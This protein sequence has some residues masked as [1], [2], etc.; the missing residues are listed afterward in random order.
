MRLMTLIILFFIVTSCSTMSQEECQ[1]INWP[2]RGK[3]DGLIGRDANSF[4]IYHEAKA[5]IKYDAT[6]QG[7]Y[8]KSRVQGIKTFCNNINWFEMGKSDGLKNRN[9]SLFPAYRKTKT[10]IEYD[11]TIQNKYEKGHAEGVR[12]FCTTKNWFETG[13]SDG[14]E[15]RSEKAFSPYHKRCVS[16]NIKGYKNRYEKGRAQGIK[17]FYI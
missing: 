4:S 1:V 16:Y 10:C 15:G 8:E 13:K 5:C 9:I 2:E 6:I 14:L 7:K 3:S 11:T 12:F 17:L